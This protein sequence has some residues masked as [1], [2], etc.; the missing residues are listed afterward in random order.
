M[1]RVLTFAAAAGL[2][3]LG[4]CPGESSTATPDPKKSP[5]VDPAL[6]ELVSRARA[7][8][9]TLKA[10]AE[11]N[12]HEVTEEKVTLGRMLYFDTRLSKGQGISC[13]TCHDLTKF[14][15]DGEKTSPGHRA[16]RGDRTSPTVYNAALHTS[17]FWDGRAK[18]V[19]EQATMPITN[20]VEMA[21]ADDATCVS[22]LKTIPGYEPL[23]KAAFPDDDDPITMGNV[24]KAIGAFERRLITPSRLDDFMSG[25]T[26]ALSAQEQRG[27]K[28]YLEVNCQMCHMGPAL[29]GN[30]FQKLG[31]V[32][33]HPNQ[34]D[35]GR[36]KVTGQDSD[37]FFFKVPSL[38]NITKTGPYYHD[39]SI[40]TLEEAIKDMAEYQL[41]KTL[42][43]EQVADL[44]AFM[45][46]LEGRIDQAY[47]AK[48]Q[49]PENGPDTPAPDPN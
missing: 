3:V 8:F 28:T 11:S 19:E 14:G 49:M 9:G 17:Q 5:A 10:E 48:P 7:T 36:A 26:D 44:V 45:G 33:E 32:K 31:L 24:G 30:M 38:R 21:M 34:G 27:L 47:I 16:Q 35:I 4:G 29:G 20:P 18:D 39:G 25:K 12:V 23:F 41:G 46:A 15:V 13:N 1:K 40:A 2:L 22:V 42:S 37:K 6:K 43:D